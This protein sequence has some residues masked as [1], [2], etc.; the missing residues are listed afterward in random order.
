MIIHTGNEYPPYHVDVGIT[1]REYQDEAIKTAIYPKDTQI[2]ALSYLTLKLNGEAGEIAELV[3]K[4]IRDDGGSNLTTERI[5]KIQKELGDVLWYIM[6]I[7]KEINCD[8]SGIAAINLAKLK[9]RQERG[10]LKGSG[11]DR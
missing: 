2:A 11:S 7:A 8:F 3:G 10:V 9:N 6:S 4:H 1:F 5:G